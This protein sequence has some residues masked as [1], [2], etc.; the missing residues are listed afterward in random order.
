M[1]PLLAVVTRLLTLDELIRRAR[2]GDAAGIGGLYDR[3]AAGL[4]CAAFR[5]TASR[6]DAEDIG[7]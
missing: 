6:A 4:Y 2:M 1:P 7:Q 3:Y 5:V